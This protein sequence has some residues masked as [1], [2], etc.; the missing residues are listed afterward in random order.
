[1]KKERGL[2]QTKPKNRRNFAFI[3]KIGR[4]KF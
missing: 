2:G 3:E 4:E 1:M